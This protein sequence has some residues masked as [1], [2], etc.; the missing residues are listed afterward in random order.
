MTAK[1]AAEAANGPHPLAVDT[2]GGRLDDAEPTEDQPPVTAVVTTY[3]RSD[4]AKRAVESVLDQTY[5]ELKLVVVEDGTDSGIEDWLRAEAIDAQYIRHDANR[6][7][8]AARN[9]AI[10]TSRTDYIAFLDDDDEWKPRRI[11][12]TVERLHAVPQEQRDRLGVVYCGTERRLNGQV[13]SIGH[14][15]NEGNLATAIMTDGASTLPSSCLFPRAALVAVG[16]YDESLPSSID[17]DI[18]M[19]LAVEGY[20]AFTVD[21]PLVV[22]H[23]PF[24]ASMSTDTARRIEG[25]RLYVEKW[26]PVY[27]EW[28]GSQRGREY[29]C[30]YF[31]AVIGRLAASKLVTGQTSEAATALGEI[32]RTC[33]YTWFLPQIIIR[34]VFEA[35]MKR[36]LP[37]LAV[38][39]M[40]A[41]AHR[42]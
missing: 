38:R 36:F 37:P 24:E 41:L 32:V 12:R 22:T 2:G 33:G 40:S 16:G 8:A 34:Q 3:D 10:A 26:T 42:L 19:A 7:L 9:T 14:P 30:R 29:A 20:D 35:I 18:W 13:L 11:E 17:H 21:E 6:G 15:E 39:H 28:F 1:R 23:N 5:E 27:Q 25:I 31:A 4:S